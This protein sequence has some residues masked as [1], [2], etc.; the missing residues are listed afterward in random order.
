MVWLLAGSAVCRAFA[1]EALLVPAAPSEPPF[2]SAEAEPSSMCVPPREPEQAPT[3]GGGTD[4]F[5]YPEAPDMPP[6]APP[7]QPFDWNGW[8]VGGRM[9]LA[10][11]INSLF[12]P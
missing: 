11:S 2:Q 4:L 1:F 9:G 5:P 8:Y 7:G 3:R 6:E 12:P 10:T